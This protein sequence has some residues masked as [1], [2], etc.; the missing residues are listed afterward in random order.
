MNDFCPLCGREKESRDW[1]SRIPDSAVE[2][3]KQCLTL[4][5]MILSSEK[6]GIEKEIKY[7]ANRLD[8]MC[9]MCADIMDGV[10]SEKDSTTFE[11][12]VNRQTEEIRV[13]I[14]SAN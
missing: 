10:E 7:L 12:R 3:R 8:E 9:P 1:D 4:E 11:R 2:L 5:K 6:K 14:G 13:R